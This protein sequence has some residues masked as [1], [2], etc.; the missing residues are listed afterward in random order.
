MYVQVFKLS[1]KWRISTVVDSFTV[2]FPAHSC[3]KLH[4]V[5]CYTKIISRRILSIRPALRAVKSVRSYIYKIQYHLG[6]LANNAYIQAAQKPSGSNYT[7]VIR[8]T[9]V[10]SP[11]MSKLQRRDISHTGYKASGDYLSAFIACWRPVPGSWIH[12]IYLMTRICRL[13]RATALRISLEGHPGEPQRVTH[14][15]KGNALS[16]PCEP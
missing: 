11:R 5:F 13:L 3:R 12:A 14:E 4:N 6:S 16:W 8:R 1:K 7:S 2:F 9:C 15:S 10:K